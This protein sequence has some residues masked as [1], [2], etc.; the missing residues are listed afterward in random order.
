MVDEGVTF[1]TSTLGLVLP[2]NPNSISLTLNLPQSRWPLFVDGPNFGPAMLFW[3]VL[4]VILGLTI[5]L[6]YVVRRQNLTIPVNTT[7]WVLLAL[8][9]SSIN[10]L[11]IVPVVLW[12]FAMEAR[13]RLKLNGRT[14]FNL[15]Q[16]GLV[17]LSL[18]A[19][20]SLFSTI[21]ASLLSAPDI[22]V[23]GNGFS[24]Y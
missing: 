21:P 12:F 18:I 24:N 7:Q 23:V 3:G 8:G 22:Q 2:L 17:V 6:G 20:I 19:M 5:G 14:G 9:M 4:I 13:S 11:R 10:I 16:M 15:Q 1:R